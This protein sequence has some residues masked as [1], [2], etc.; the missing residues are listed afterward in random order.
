MLRAGDVDPIDQGHP[1]QHQQAVKGDPYFQ[2][3]VQTQGMLTFQ[4][5][6]R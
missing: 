4:T 2:E 5:Q 3:R 1:G 6:T